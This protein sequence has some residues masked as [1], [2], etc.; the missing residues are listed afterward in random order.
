M[1]PTQANFCHPYQP[2]SIQ[3]DFMK[4]LYRCIE[5]NKV[6]IFESPTGTGKSLSLI[7]GALTWLRDHE[8]LA[9][10]GPTDGHEPYDWLLEAEKSAQRRELLLEREELELRLATIREE[11]ASRRQKRYDVKAS[12]KPRTKVA[13]NDDKATDEDEFILEDYNS[14]GE[15]TNAA[16]HSSVSL[17]SSTQAL[18]DKLQGPTRTDVEE[19]KDR[20]KIIFC[21]R[22]H[23]QLTQFVNE[24]R[25]VKPPSSIRSEAADITRKSSLEEGVKH[26]AL[27]SRK[28]LCI[29]PKVARLSSTTAI[30]EQCLELQKPAT[31]K[32]KRCPYIPTKDDKVKVDDFRDRVVAEI[33]DIEDTSHL[34]KEMQLCP[35]YASR[36]AISMSEVL[37][38]PYPLL[39][40]KS[41]RAALGVSV[42]DNVVIIDEAHNLMDAIADTFSISLRLGQLEQGARQVTAYASRFKNRLK[43][44]NRVYVMQVIRLLTSMIDCL[45]ETL[46]KGTSAQATITATQL[47]SGKGVD[48]IKPHK[49]LQYLHE[50]KLCHKVEG[51]SEAQRDHNDSNHSKGALL[52]FQNFLIVLMNPDDEGRF[53]TSRQDNDVVVHYT[54]LDPREHFREIVQESR[55]VILAGGTMSP[56]SDYSDYLF[57]Y[58]DRDRLRTFSFGHIIPPSHLFAQ[59]VTRGSSGVEFDFRYEMRGSEKMILELGE[60]VVRTC[61]IVPDGVVV[62]FPSYDYL[63]RVLSVWQHLPASQP[64]MHALGK[65]KTIFQESKSVAVD[66][67]LQEYATAVDSGKGGLMLSVVGGK[68]SE[69]INFSD[70]LGRAVL[71]VGLPFPNANG[72]EWKAKMEH[73]E[74]I[75]YEHCKG[76][77]KGEAECRA[78]AKIAS[79]EYY[80]NACMRAVNQSIGRVIRHRNDYAA[81]LM[82]DRRFSSERISRK[83]PGWIHG[84]MKDG[85][86]DWTAI[87]KGIHVF[88]R[89]KQ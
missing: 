39:L 54:L 89:G 36:A 50:S 63:A 4:E 23:S 68:L 71:A 82:V 10:Q 56:M 33:R 70:K 29:N 13:N 26:L 85:L 17:S 44:K 46:R 27:G 32:D 55:A 1:E 8:H 64:V 7:C 80:E 81:I 84:S 3:L 45:R 37:T 34:G 78:E 28:N 47:M 60:L 65:V 86:R 52:H 87:E 6:G 49:L 74:G 67:L 22:T 62:F 19:E 76:Q 12:K 25:R 66:E 14:E 11:E 40:Q 53:F 18:L 21:S 2:Y 41:A 77:G 20:L 5:E 9:L 58:L 59:A 30:N 31:P 72:A 38:L 42:K 88:F 61:R 15:E 48:Q 83:L 57:S 75:R 69:G 16:N 35:Y 24:L 51:Y 43:G 73:I 79:R